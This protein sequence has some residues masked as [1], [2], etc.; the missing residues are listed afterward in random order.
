MPGCLPRVRYRARWKPLLQL[1]LT[2][3]MG[4]DSNFLFSTRLDKV[5]RANTFAWE[6]DTCGG[7][8]QDETIP[9]SWKTMAVSGRGRWM[10]RRL[11]GARYQYSAAWLGWQRILLIW[12]RTKG[13]RQERHR[14]LRGERSTKGTEFP[15]LGAITE[16]NFCTRRHNIRYYDR[17]RSKLRFR[18]C[19]D[20][21]PKINPHKGVACFGL[22]ISMMMNVS[23]RP[24]CVFRESNYV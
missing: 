8:T 7:Q 18:G 22:S 5:K 11:C 12:P 14:G 20:G 21:D 17:A 2:K 13:R 24:N 1:V 3:E 15:I 16:D 4:K 19:I 10:A 9:Q 6:E 23:G